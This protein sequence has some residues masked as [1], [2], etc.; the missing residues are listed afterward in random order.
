MGGLGDSSVLNIYVLMGV[1]VELVNEKRWEYV[2]IVFN[3]GEGGWVRNAHQKLAWYLPTASRG[4]KYFMSAGNVETSIYSCLFWMNMH[5]IRQ[6]YEWKRNI[7]M[8]IEIN[9]Q[10]NRVEPNNEIYGFYT[11]LWCVCVLYGKYLHLVN[12][13]QGSQLFSADEL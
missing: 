12:V 6:R 7:S 9:W 2:G 13:Y 1:V 4:R 11:E 5:E 3:W 10:R 8:E